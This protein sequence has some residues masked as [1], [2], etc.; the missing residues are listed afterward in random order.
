[1]FFLSTVETR[2]LNIVWLLVAGTDECTRLRPSFVASRKKQVP[3][4]PAP[5]AVPVIELPIDQVALHQVHVFPT[6][7]TAA[8][9][10]IPTVCQDPFCGN[11][12]GFLW[13]SSGWWVGRRQFWWHWLRRLWSSFLPRML[14][15]SFR[16]RALDSSHASNRRPSM[17][18]I[19]ILGNIGEDAQPVWY[20]QSNHILCIQQCWDPQLLLCHS[21]CQLVVLVHIFFSEGIKVSLQG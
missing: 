10:D 20:L 1:M 16:G 3:T 2:D 9:G 11:W 6:D 17:E 5:E 18:V 21:K 7:P 8:A 14:L 15:W 13:L 4:L 12:G 19:I